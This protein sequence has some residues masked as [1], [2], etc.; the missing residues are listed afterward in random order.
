M[1]TTIYKFDFKK[2]YLQISLDLKKNSFCF[3]A[4]NTYF[5]QPFNR[6][7]ALTFFLLCLF[8]LFK[9]N[10]ISYSKQRKRENATNN[11]K[12][13]LNFFISFLLCNRA[14]NW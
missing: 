12:E 7:M 14:P 9:L 8:L 2:I 10:L 11:F 13:I 4:N 5:T 1:Y 3:V 6:N